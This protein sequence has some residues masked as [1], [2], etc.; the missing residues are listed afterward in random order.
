MRNRIPVRASETVAPA[1]RKR[2]FLSEPAE[3]ENPLNQ[4]CSGSDTQTVVIIRLLRVWF[5][6][7]SCFLYASVQQFSHTMFAG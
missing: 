7:V 2:F 3:E 4:D 5:R 6:F 1:N